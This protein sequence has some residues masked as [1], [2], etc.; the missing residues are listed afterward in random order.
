MIASRDIIAVTRQLGSMMEA[1]VDI[2]RALR[3]LRAQTE[4]AE[5]LALYDRLVHDLRLGSGLADAMSRAPEVFSPFAI[6]LLRQGEARGDLAGS[7]YRIADYL[8]KEQEIDAPPTVMPTTIQVQAPSLSSENCPVWLHRAAA[9]FMT[10]LSGYLALLF[11]LELFVA[12]DYVPPRWHLSA[13]VALTL[14]FC[15]IVAW[16]LRQ[17]ISISSSSESETPANEQEESAKSTFEE[18]GPAPEEATFE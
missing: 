2:L 3:V 7:F 8:Q 18:S 5:W 6:S 12:A 11:V 4:D 17:D 16:R 13:I 15:L 9:Q 10:H 14:A 1:G